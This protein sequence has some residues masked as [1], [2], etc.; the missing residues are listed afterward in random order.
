MGLFDKLKFWKKDDLGADVPPMEGLPPLPGEV[1][2]PGFGDEHVGAGAAPPM[3][4]GP[5]SFPQSPEFKEPTPSFEPR[6][7]QPAMQPLRPQPS[8]DLDLVNAKLDAIKAILDNVNQRLA[9]LERIARDE[10]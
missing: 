8:Q 6:M 4:H 1:K 10:I 2:E 9:N 5:G 7:P 3:M